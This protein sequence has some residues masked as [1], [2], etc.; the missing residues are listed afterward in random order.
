[1][2][3]YSF[4]K[5]FAEPILLGAKAQTIR[6]PRKRHARPGEQIQL[7]TGMRTKHCRLLARVTCREVVPVRL[8]FSRHGAAELIRIGDRLM[9]T[10]LLD[11]F[12][13]Q[14]GFQDIGDMARFW[15]AEHPPAEGDTLTF[16]GVLITWTPIQNL[17]ALA[18]GRAA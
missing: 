1:M 4:K 8:C 7:Y 3:A 16:E 2:V 10:A 6:A 13:R 11:A 15:W 12:A 9:A 18:A 14:D 17:D 5:R